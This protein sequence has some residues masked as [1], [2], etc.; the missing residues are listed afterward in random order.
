MSSSDEPSGCL[1]QC[2]EQSYRIVW[3][4]HRPIREKPHISPKFYTGLN[5]ENVWYLRLDSWNGENGYCN[6][7]LFLEE[8]VSP[9]GKVPVRVDFFIS[10][11]QSK[12]TENTGEQRYI[13]KKNGISLLNCLRSQEIRN[14]YEHSASR[15]GLQI[16]CV[17][18]HDVIPTR[19]M[20]NNSEN[21]MQARC[22]H[23]IIKDLQLMVNDDKFSDVELVVKKE[24]F[25]AHKMMLASRSPVFAAMFQN[26]MQE[27]QSN[28]VEIP[29]FSPG[30]VLKLLSYIYT[31]SVENIQDSVDD[32]IAAAEKYQLDGLKSM[33]SKVIIEKLDKENVIASL[34]LANLYRIDDLKQ[35]AMSFIIDNLKN[36]EEIDGFDAFM[37]SHPSLMK[38]LLKSF[39]K[40]T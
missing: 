32:L 20:K 26:D 35:E 29:D 28:I 13:G 4:I 36:L 27:N 5:K 39:S 38:E 8:C 21:E 9:S 25:H 23:R 24:K 19:R 34:I 3:T 12:E 40:G 15:D 2:F 33:C 7:M 6:L 17:I 37:A 22:R 16:R 31:D 14:A 10:G 11:R 18:T 30:V 1:G